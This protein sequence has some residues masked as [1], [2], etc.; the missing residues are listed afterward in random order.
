MGMCI[1]TVERSG[2]ISISVEHGDP[3]LLSEPE[4]SR[5]HQKSPRSG[6]TRVS[7]FLPPWFHPQLERIWRSCLEPDSRNTFNTDWEQGWTS[8]ITSINSIRAQ[9]T[10]WNCRSDYSLASEANR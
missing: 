7:L 10:I 9:S 1:C 3:S 6:L 5:E 8:A 4:V 2:G